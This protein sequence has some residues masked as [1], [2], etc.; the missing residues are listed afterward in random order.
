MK[1]GIFDSGIGGVTVLKEILKVLPNEDYLYY[2]DSINN[3]Y[4]EKS[5]EEI[6]RCCDKIV[7][8]LINQHCQIIVIACN[9]ASANAS[10]YLRDK[11]GNIPILA[12]EPAYK[13]IHDYAINDDALV[14][15]T[16]AT[17]ESKKFQELYNLYNN[18]KTTLIECTGLANL[19]ENNKEEDIKKYLE[20]NIGKYSGEVKSVVLGCT[21]YPLIKA[22]IKNILGSNI[23]IFDGAPGLA[24][25]L[26]NIIKNIGYTSSNNLNID[27][28][29]SS[30]SLI[31]KERFF[32][33]LNN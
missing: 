28:F 17:I 8:Y 5:I 11:Y 22:Q 7:D 23:K 26:Q 9:T 24:K 15:A 19:I 32:N 10:E 12:I 4:G 3:P 6:I 21:H 2:S 27:F 13:M 31:K 16:P 25:H 33:Y 20:E 14:L 1:I 29:D 30:L 18:N